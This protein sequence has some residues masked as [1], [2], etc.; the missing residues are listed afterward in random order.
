[1]TMTMTM[2]QR[3][4]IRVGSERTGCDWQLNTLYCLG[5]YFTLHTYSFALTLH[6]AFFRRNAHRRTALLKLHRARLQALEKNWK[7]QMPAVVE[8]YLQW[9]HGICEDSVDVRKGS[10]FEVT[11]IHTFCES[12]FSSPLLFVDL[13]YILK[14][15]NA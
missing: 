4:H 13:M 2:S 11:A 8:A 3:Y 14:L 15:V 7:D 6:L 10:V 5:I 9:K 1:M 12:P